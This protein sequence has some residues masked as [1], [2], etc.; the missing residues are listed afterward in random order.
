MSKQAKIKKI[1]GTFL[2]VTFLAGGLTL[3][4]ATK[5]HAAPKAA[6]PAV[7]A[8]AMIN[9]NKANVE[10]LD[11]IRGIDLRWRNGSSIFERK[12]ARSR[13]LMTLF[14]FAGRRLQAPAD[15]K[16]GHGL[17]V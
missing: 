13:A 4:A 14:R 1:M 16:S 6:A 12:T 2:V 10:E 15:Q 11:K 8:P 9:I 17:S 5:V 7:S 3:A